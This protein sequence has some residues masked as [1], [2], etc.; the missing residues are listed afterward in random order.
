MLG[1]KRRV[2][3]GCDDLLMLELM[4]KGREDGKSEEYEDMEVDGRLVF[5]VR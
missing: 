4:G 1:E 5:E 2:E 3:N